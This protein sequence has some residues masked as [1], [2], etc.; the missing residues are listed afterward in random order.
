MKRNRNK[1]VFK[2]KQ[3][4]KINR[5]TENSYTQTKKAEIQ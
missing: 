2:N 5:K 4:K 1:V 3:K